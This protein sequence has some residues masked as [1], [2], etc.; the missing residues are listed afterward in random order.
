MH[1]G[2]LTSTVVQTSSMGTLLSE[3]E[4]LV[5]KYKA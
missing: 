4:A 1:Y 2:T 3:L 5:E